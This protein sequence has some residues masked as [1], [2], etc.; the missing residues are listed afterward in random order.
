MPSNRNQS[1]ILLIAGAIGALVGLAAGYTL[2]KR[3]D[4]RDGQPALTAR[5]GVSLGMLVLGLL[6]QVAQLGDGD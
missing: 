1:Q 5:E 3:A 4:E 6:R 2:L